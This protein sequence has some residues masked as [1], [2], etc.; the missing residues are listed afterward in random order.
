MS[1]K[2][3]MHES[4]MYNNSMIDT[5]DKIGIMDMWRLWR[6]RKKKQRPKEKETISSAAVALKLRRNHRALRKQIHRS[7][8]MVIILFKLDLKLFKFLF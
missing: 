1:S 7:F 8:F 2:V 5:Q 4:I 6:K 3:I